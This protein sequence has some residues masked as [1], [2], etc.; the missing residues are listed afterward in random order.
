MPKYDK[1]GNQKT[2][3]KKTTTKY[4]GK[5][6][7]RY[8]EHCYNGGSTPQFCRLEKISRDTFDRWIAT[9]D[10][11]G[12]VK[13]TAKLWAEGWW[14]QQA[15]NHLVIHNDKDAGNTKFDTALYK[16]MTGGRFGHTSDKEM[17]EEITKIKERLNTLGPQQSSGS[18][19]EEPEYTLDDT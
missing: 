4:D 6:F 13:K 10:T 8:L 19:A 3:N 7:E 11:K 5:I 16:Y 15:Q 17:L 1:N 14:I 2:V 9:Y 18:I 12:E